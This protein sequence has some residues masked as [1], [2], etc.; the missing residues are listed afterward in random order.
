MAKHLLLL[1]FSVQFLLGVQAQQARHIPISTAAG[2][3][4]YSQ[5]P[6]T[7]FGAASNLASTAYYTQ[8]GG[9]I[10]AEKRFNITELTNSYANIFIPIKKMGTLG[11]AANFIGDATFNE[12]NLQLHYARKLGSQAAIGVGFNYYNII[13]TGYLKASTL[14]ATISAVVH[15]SPLVTVGV[16][17]AQI[18]PSTFGINKT[19]KLANI[20]QIGIGYTPSTNFYCSG[21]LV[22]EEDYPLYAVIKFRYKPIDKLALQAGISTHNNNY[23]FGVSFVTN[24]L[25]VL[26]GLGYQARLGSSPTLAVGYFK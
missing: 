22:K 3:G 20:M 4:A 23:N 1:F 14:N 26:V 11:A 18:V 15:L 9:G 17:A 21:E 5:K 16:Q 19:E 25:D 6:L 10:L 12:T 2:L 8:A 13:A 7:A 24:K